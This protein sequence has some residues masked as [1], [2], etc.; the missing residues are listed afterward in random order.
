MSLT[1]RI[2]SLTSVWGSEATQLP[3]ATG[4]YHNLICANT[5]REHD[6]LC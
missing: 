4:P 1:V 2:I 5:G 6:K 3:Q